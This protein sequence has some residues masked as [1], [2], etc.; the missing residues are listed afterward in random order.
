MWLEQNLKDG[1]TGTARDQWAPVK[2]TR[3]GY[4]PR[5]IKVKWKDRT[6]PVRDRSCVFAEQLAEQQWKNTATEDQL[7]Y[8]SS[9][10]PLRPPDPNVPLANS[11]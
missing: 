8:V 3:K 11:T 10:P 5:H 4:Q 6:H 2:A 7:E 1:A 9:L